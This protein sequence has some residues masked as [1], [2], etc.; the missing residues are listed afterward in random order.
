MIL[1]L[2]RLN[3]SVVYHHFKMSTL[4]SAVQLMTKNCYMASID[5][6]DAYY[7]VSI[8]EEHR[9]LLRF[10][11]EGKLYEFQALPNG[12]ACEP[13]LFTKITKPFFAY[14]RKQGFNN[15]P[16]I[17]DSFLMG[18]SKV[19]CR[20][21]VM[22]TVNLS[23]NVGFIVHPTKSIFEP[24]QILEYLGFI[25]NSILMR[26]SVNERQA[27]KIA[28]ACKDL[29]KNT[30]IKVIDLA[31]VV[32]LLV[33]SFPGV[34]YGRLYYRHLDNVKTSALKKGKGDYNAPVH[35]DGM[36]RD[37]LEWLINN[38]HHTHNPISHGNPSL[39]IRSDASKTGWGAACGGA[40]TGGNWSNEEALNHINYLELLAAWFALR[41]FAKE[42]SNIHIK[43]EID[44]TTALAYVGNMGGRL[45][46][47]NTLAREIWIWCKSR[48]IYLS[49]AYIASED[50]TDADL[51]SRMSHDNIEWMLNKHCFHNI[52]DIFGKPE[53]DLFASRLNKQLDC[54]VSWKPD[55]FAWTVDAFTFDWSKF[56]VYAFPPFTLIGRILQKIELDMVEQAI[57]IVP[58]WTTQP[59]LSKLGKMLINCPLLLPRRINTLLHPT[60]AKHELNKLQLIACNLSGNTTRTVEFRKEEQTFCC[61][62]G[63]TQ[64]KNNIIPTSKDGY[65]FVVR[66][67]S[68]SCHQI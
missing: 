3:E 58:F 25:L 12:L 45:F 11:F 10:T 46:Q 13:R 28:S 27:T 34:Q 36:C 6:K 61:P 68:I 19:E 54:Y 21:N 57:V 16:Y 51:E 26:I 64:R 43:L 42:L 14:L 38:I 50:N 30:K 24:T 37:D 32:G 20:Q 44:N 8:R 22:S 63:E 9:K 53:I 29:I 41:C 33:A 60:K 62:L 48:N 47:M 52:C 7:C 40:T 56:F 39:M 66:G 31:R 5:W 65:D 67:M 2:K 18:E 59:W 1:N 35:L 17:D 23:N 15:S 4:Q 55:P 49:V